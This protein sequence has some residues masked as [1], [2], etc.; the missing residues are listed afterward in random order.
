M[1]NFFLAHR[2]R[3][4]L[5]AADILPVSQQPCEAHSPQ[6]QNSK[7]KQ[8]K[9]TVS[10]DNRQPGTRRFHIPQKPRSRRVLQHKTA[11]KVRQTPGGRR[12]ACGRAAEGR[13]P[14]AIGPSQGRPHPARPLTGATLS[15]R[16]PQ[17]CQLTCEM[18]QTSQVHDLGA[19]LHGGYQTNGG[20]GP[21]RTKVPP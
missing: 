13:S 10:E 11:S 16:F 7:R 18:I 5:N 21:R 17:P 1:Q 9:E 6:H 12:S 8:N 4:Y 2:S 20:G 3:S 14:V 19:K 15:A